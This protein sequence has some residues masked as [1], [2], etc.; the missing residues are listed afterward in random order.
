MAP[1]DHSTTQAPTASS[2]KA[3]STPLDQAKYFDEFWKN[4]PPG[5]GAKILYT[6]A[7]Q[8]L[9]QHGKKFK[10]NQ[11]YQLFAPGELATVMSA[12]VRLHELDNDQGPSID[13]YA[14]DALSP[15]E[16][17]A[18]I[19][20]GLH[21]WEH[22]YSRKFKHRITSSTWK[23]VET[24]FLGLLRQEELPAKFTEPLETPSEED[25]HELHRYRE[26][27]ETD[28]WGG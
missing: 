4:V 18:Q 16:F 13:P 17:T 27:N 24:L 1:K 12:A 15:E 10:D 6:L 8:Q 21:A 23:F 9:F 19:M 7:I 26:T 25:I 3:A 5:N 28:V 2:K 20:E 14:V 11:D 22:L